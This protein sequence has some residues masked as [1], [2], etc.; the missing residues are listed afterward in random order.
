MARVTARDGF[1]LAGLGEPLH[2]VFP[3]GLEHAEAGLDGCPF[4]PDRANQALVDE[5]SEQVECLAAEIVDASA[6]AGHLLDGIEIRPTGED[7]EASEK[8]P[9]RLVE[10]V[11]A[12]GDR[13]AQ[14]SLAIGQVDG[15]RRE[16]VEAAA[17]AR[18][19]R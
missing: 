14:G 3:D 19:D 6:T 2:G 13:A 1:A 12:P 16:Q 7:R 4:F 10:Q 18:E 11:E 17:E 9:L 8:A 5:L 15:P